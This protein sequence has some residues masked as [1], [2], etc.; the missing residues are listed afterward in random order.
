M[1]K[2]YPIIKLLLNNKYINE[3]QRDLI[4][5][6]EDEIPNEIDLIAESG[7]FTEKEIAI[8]LGK[9]FNMDFV[10]LEDTQ[11]NDD[12]NETIP[13]NILSRLLAMPL[14]Q[15]EVSLTIAIS[16]PTNIQ[17]LESLYYYTNKKI[18]FCT[19]EKS[20]IEK[21]YLVQSSQ[22]TS[23]EAIEILSQE[24]GTEE[25]INENNV[26][27]NDSD[28]PSIKLTNSI[29]SEG[30]TMGAS[31][32]HIEPYETHL[33]VRYRL[34]GILKEVLRLPGNITPAIIA[35]FKMMCGMDISERRIPQEGRLE[36]TLIG[37]AVDLRFSSLPNVFG[38]KLVI[39]ILAK[40]FMGKALKS[41]GFNDEDYA[42]VK[43]MLSRRDGIVL[44]TGP[45]G[46]GK[47]TTLYSFLNE[48]KSSEKA[49]VTVEDPVE[50]TI[51]GFNQTQVNTKQGMT[52]PL[53]LRA[54]LRQDPD[55]IMIGEIRD[56]ETANIAVRSSITGHLVFSTLHTNSALSS[57]MRLADMGVRPYLLSDSVRGVIA[58]RLVRRLCPDCKVA[59]TS[60]NI[61]MKDLGIS[62]PTTIY[63]PVGCNRCNNIGYKGRFPI[64]EVL[65]I[66]LEMKKLIQ[67]EA[68]A[69]ILE[70]QA[71]KENMRLLY[72]C[73][74]E[75]VLKGDTSI[76]ELRGLE[77]GD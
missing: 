16:D 2:K 63:K 34:D 28:A 74:V 68:D 55:I 14:W 13:K 73:G 69:D 51:E 25:I 15:D 10:D 26:L 57:I 18:V 53:A 44:V 47:S 50:Y 4:V 22:S 39:R 54:I 33:L 66:S 36:V 3:A 27:S 46:S 6:K 59:Y 49:I 21:R 45:T 8:H 71:K 75:S 31:D 20:L 1:A 24:F 19:A 37:K 40:E 17:G 60:T 32:I 5:A 64:F 42:K 41:I 77:N 70:L 30:I 52:F 61:E 7:V 43:K 56:E 12:V 48:M 62:E 35:R 58:Q 23:S 9:L 67:D 29:L 65:N 72:D 11:V 38:E 76:Q